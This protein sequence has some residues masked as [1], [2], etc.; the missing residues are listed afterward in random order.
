LDAANE[1]SYATEDCQIATTRKKTYLYLS[2]E[3][4][5][6]DPEKAIITNRSRNEEDQNNEAK[7]IWVYG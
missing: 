7:G 6:S 4:N 3:K 2:K 5:T 1:A